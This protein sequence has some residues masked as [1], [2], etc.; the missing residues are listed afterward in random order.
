M[1]YR[2]ARISFFNE[3]ENVQ[4]VILRCNTLTLKPLTGENN[5]KKSIF[6]GLM[7]G[8][9]WWPNICPAKAPHELAGFV[10]GSRMADFKDKVEAGT[11]LP[12]RY[13]ES[14]KEVEAKEIKG[15]KTGLVVYAT[16]IQP[17]RIVRLKFKYTDASKR[18]FDELLKRYKTRFGEPDEWRGDPFHIVIAWKWHFTD[19]DGNRISLIVW[20]NTRDEEE[21]E[22]NAVKMTMWNL[23]MDEQRC[24]EKKHPETAE[25]EGL[26]ISFTDPKAVDWNRLIPE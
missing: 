4:E 7:I 13:L 10:L 3:K 15:F 5:M 20:H 19:E 18:F 22:G 25:S 12:I 21:K 24:Y 16:C 9:L 6:L 1:E 8:M 17:P 14:L 2:L 26:D 11:V 23:I